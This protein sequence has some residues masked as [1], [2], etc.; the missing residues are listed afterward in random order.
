[1]GRTRVGRRL[2]AF[3]CSAVAVSVLAACGGGSSAGGD[4]ASQPVKI[5]L[6]VEQTGQFSWY[7][8]EATNGAKLYVK[9]H[10][11]AGDRP[12]QF[13]TYDT[14]SDPEKAVTGFRKLAQQDKVAAV[15]GLGLTNEAAIVAP[16][17]QSL[18][19]PFYALSGSFTPPNSMTF[20]MPVQ[21]GDMQD[22]VFKQ[23]KSQGVK[24]FGLLTTNDATGQIADGLFT[25]L[26]Q[27]YDLKLVAHEHMAGTDVDVTPQLTNIAAKKPDLVIA[28][29]VGKPLGVVFNSAHQLD[30]KTPFL[31]SY[32]NLAP[33]FL[34]SLAAIQPETVYT[35]ATKDVFWNSLPSSDPQAAV[36]KKFHDDYVAEFSDETGLGSA[37]GYDAVM[38]VSKAIA[39][40][41]STDAAKIV[42]ALEG[43]H[44]VKGVFGTYNLTKTNHVGLT[45]SDTVLGQVSAGQIRLAANS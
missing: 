42:S 8:S 37:S 26:G 30:I 45:G 43:M 15:V 34:K 7:G 23:M 29:E 40:A 20:A 3:A 25:K 31:I 24:S 12:I 28:W 33:G 27:K 11:K 10:P 36:V 4:S 1:V 17:A 19:I 44:G 2:L 6:L 21:I 38:L 9:Q 35:Q 32:G 22:R 13:V 5:G 18:K 39:E 41:N 14:G 16:L